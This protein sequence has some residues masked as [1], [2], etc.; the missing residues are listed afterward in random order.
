MRTGLIARD[1]DTNL[2]VETATEKTSGIELKQ[3]QAK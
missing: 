3:N 1:L 2:I